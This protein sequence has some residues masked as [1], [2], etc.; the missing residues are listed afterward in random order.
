M[1]LGFVKE[2]QDSFS[3]IENVFGLDNCNIYGVM[4]GHGTNGHFVSQF[5]GEA[6]KKFFLSSINSKGNLSPFKVSSN[7][8]I[9][10]LISF[11]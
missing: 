8:F 9:V 10:F 4:D 2:N 3:F 1:T 6:L 5:C 7:F 11:T